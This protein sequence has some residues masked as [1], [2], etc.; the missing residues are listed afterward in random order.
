MDATPKTKKDKKK[1][2]PTED[3]KV[4]GKELIDPKE[5]GN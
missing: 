1:S 5:D 3:I 2:A 4:E